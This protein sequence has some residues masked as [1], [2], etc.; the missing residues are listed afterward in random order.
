MEAV[1]R[2]GDQVPRPTIEIGSRNLCETAA[3][4]LRHLVTFSHTVTSLLIHATLIRV[5]IRR[6]NLYML[7]GLIAIHDDCPA[8]RGAISMSFL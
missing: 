6:A 2:A 5:G 3:R 1:P 7:H 8:G 4:S